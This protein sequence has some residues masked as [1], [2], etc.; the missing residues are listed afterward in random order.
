LYILQNSTSYS[1]IIYVEGEMNQS[2]MDSA[3]IGS[4]YDDM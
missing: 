3:I 2:A 1:F 4:L